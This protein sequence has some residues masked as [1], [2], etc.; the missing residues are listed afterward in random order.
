MTVLIAGFMLGARDLPPPDGLIDLRWIVIIVLPT[1]CF[2]KSGKYSRVQIGRSQQ[3][4]LIVSNSARTIAYAAPGQG[5]NAIRS[6]A[7]PLTP[8]G[9]RVS[10]VKLPD[11][12]SRAPVSSASFLEARL[13]A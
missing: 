11:V 2:S 3:L 13:L 1:N 12:L 10:F 5:G 4:S 8:R 6:R 7:A 9:A